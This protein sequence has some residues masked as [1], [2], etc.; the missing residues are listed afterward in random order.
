MVEGLD[1]TLFDS[2]I[3]GKARVVKEQ[4]RQAIL[5]GGIDW[6]RA[7]QPNCTFICPFI[8]LILN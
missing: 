4:I 8:L 3:Q 6:Y 7:P 1:K 2:Y 5:G